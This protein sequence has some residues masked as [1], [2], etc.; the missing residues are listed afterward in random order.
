MGEAKNKK[1]AHARVLR[2]QP[3]CIYCG[4]TTLADTIEHMP[5][6]QMF[7]LRQRPKGMEFPACR[8]CNNGTSHSDLVASLLGRMYPDAEGDGAIAELKKLLSGVAINVPGLLEEMMISEG[9][10]RR[11][12]LTIPKIPAG[13]AVLRANGPI[14]ENHMKIFGAKLG[15][16]VH[17]EERR[18]IIPPEGGVQPL[19]YTN[20]NAAR[21]E[22]P[23]EIIKLLPEPPKTLRQGMKHV[24]NQFS[25]SW[26]PTVEGRHNLAYAVFNEAFAILAVTTLDRSVFLDQNAIRYPVF[27]PGDFKKGH[28]LVPSQ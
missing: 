12:K 3:N 20:V 11:A 2:E 18:E 13:G 15:F 14:L 23:D 4:G 21:G 22:L 10:E 6:I 28:A 25:Y 17:F 27:A 1:R 9:E 26:L 19:Y 8:P 5:P 7:R 24:T 16:A